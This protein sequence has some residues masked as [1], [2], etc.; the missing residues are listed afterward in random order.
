MMDIDQLEIWFVTGSQHL[1]G[2]ETLRQV[3]DDSM[4]IAS[5]LD[6]SGRIPVKVVFKPVLTTP[7]AITQLCIDANATP[8]CIGL[9]TWMHTFSPAKMWIAGLKLLQ[10]PFVHLH[11]QFN[12]DIPWSEI[13][14]D[15]MNLNQSAHGGREFGFI[16]TRMR[17]DRKVIVG[18]WQDD[19]VVADLETWVRA[20]SAWHDAQGAKIARFGDN[21][22]DV[23]VTEGDKVAAQIQ[24][25]YSVYGYG[26]GDLVSYVDAVTEASINALLAEYD[27]VY[28]VVESLREGG[29][30]RGE[31]R[32]AAQIESG[33]RAFLE[34]GNFKG[35]TTTFEDLHGLIQLPGL[36]VQRLM[37][38]GYGFGAEGDW[39]TA[40]LVR[41]MKVMSVGMDG[42][43]SFMEDYTYHL[44]PGRMKVLG[45]HMLEVCASIAADKPRLEMHPLSIGGKADPARLVFNVP[46]GP[47]VNASVI[48]LGNR[49][50]MVV[51][52]V[53]VVPPDADLPKLPVARVVWVPKPNLKVGA[54]AWILAGG[55]H[56]TSFSQAV[57]VA[58]LE[59]F[60]EMAGMELVL[61]DDDTKL[62]TI[63]KELR[64]NELYYHLARGL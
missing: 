14:M 2:D 56:H 20:A 7:G 53:E 48:D 28:S 11:T 39:K 35:F 42:G 64:W 1:Y 30:Q 41:A 55:A 38:D 21:M 9:I 59:D 23:A 51:N 43:T 18:Y 33:M 54:A 49:F 32:K 27:E 29:S 62:S 58:H 37:A 12:R 61:I 16:G 17:I 45:A 36:A 19:Q 52:P 13:D 25:G 31:L 10:K 46:T 47:A 4:A 44:E 63:K 40:A 22:R 3:A 24:L 50:R 34:E 26:I 5:G 60:A 15:F 57:T 8:H 6:R